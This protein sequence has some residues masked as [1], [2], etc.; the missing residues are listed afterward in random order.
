MF[1]NWLPRT[2]TRTIPPLR[3]GRRGASPRPSSRLRLEALEDR[4]APATHIWVGPTVGGLWSAAANWNGGAPT[5][6]EAGGTIV[7]FNG[8][9][10][11]IDDIAGLVVNQIHFT[12]D[13]NT[14]RGITPLGIDGTTV[15][16]NLLNDAGS[17][18]LDATLPLVLSGG[19]FVALLSAG[20]VTI[21]GSVSGNEGLNLATGSAGTLVLGG[22]AANTYTGTTTIQDG[23]LLLSKP[24]G[25]NAVGGNVSVG[26]GNGVLLS[27]VL[28]LAAG[29]QI[30]DAATVTVHADGLFDLFDNSDT[31]TALNI[32]G[33][34]VDSGGGTLTLSGNVTA[35]SDAA[36]DAAS[37]LG[38]LALGAGS[39]TVSD[40]PVAATNDLVVAATITGGTGLTLT[41]AS[42]GQMVVS[43]P[44]NAY[45]GGTIVLGGTLILGT[46]NA[47]P[48]P[49]QVAAD[50]PL[51][52]TAPGTLDLNGFDQEVASINGTG[53]I[54]DSGV[55]ATLTANNAAA[56]TFAGLLSGSLD[57][58]KNNI[59]TLTLTASNT[60]SGPT[61]INA[62]TLA[63]GIVDALPAGTSVIVAAAGT[64]D[65]AGFNQTVASITGAGTITD[66]SAT[67]ATLTVNN[68]SDEAFDG[69]LSGKLALTKAGNGALTLQGTAANTYTGTTTITDGTLVLN[70]PAGVNA[71]GGNVTVGDGI[72]VL[73]SD[74]LQLA[75]SN[76][77]PDSATVTV[78]SDGLF[79]LF[80]NSET[81]AALNI[82]GG[83]VDSGGGTLTLLGNVTATSDAAGD[84]ASILGNLALGAGAGSFVVT[85]GP[86]AA[87]NDLVVAA[88]LTG[89]TGLTLT[90][91]STGQMVLSAPD[92]AYTGG[93]MI[94]GGTLLLGAS[95]ALPVPPQ[96]A[97]DQPL[98]VT[99][100][101]TLDLNGFDQEVASISGTGTITDSGVQATLT[102]NNTAADTFAGL[103]S[104]SLALT[105]IG[106]GTLTLT[107][108][109]T[110]TGPTTINAGTLLVNGTQ[111]NSS[112]SVF[113]P[114]TLGGVGTTGPVNAGI[115]TPATAGGTVAPGNPIGTL[116]TGSIV[117][118]QGANFNVDINGTTPGT[119]FDVLNVT[120][121]VT[122]TNANLRIS[123]NISIPPGT[124][125][126]IL[127]NDGADPISGT[128]SGLPEGARFLVNGQRFSISYVGGDGNDIVLTRVNLSDLAIAKTGPAGPVAEGT[129]ITYMITV[130]NSGPDD[131][132]N[133]VVTDAVPAGA[134]LN[135]LNFPQGARGAGNTFNLG[136]VTNGATVTG[137]AVITATEEGALNDVA[138]VSSTSTDPNSANNTSTATT[139]VTE[140]AISLIGAAINGFEFM[141]P[142][143]PV[144]VATLIHANGVEPATDFTASINWGDGTSS[145]GQVTL[146]GLTYSIKGGHV[147]NDEGTFHVTV[148]V[149]E[150]NGSNSTTTTATILEELLP[151][152]TR[153]TAN[154]RFLSEV[155]RNMLARKI[156]SA[157][158]TTWNAEL[159]AGATRSQVVHDIQDSPS[160]EFRNDEVQALY[161]QFLHRAADPTG[162]NNAVAFLRSG[163]TVEQLA[164][165]LV[166]SAEYNQRTNGSN[167]GW[168]DTIY[169]DALHRAV[170]A[171]GRVGWDA[172]FAAG[173]SR[174][175]V[176]SAIFA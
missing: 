174:A 19:N 51:T 64:Y 116:N 72:G 135:S 11:S 41:A 96:V 157:G 162:L 45:T 73:L 26:D 170:D 54:T 169:Q 10:D 6:G 104:G 49:P 172:A 47:L 90:A 16:N 63:N 65:L 146:T 27:D 87:T 124:T 13:A 70:K 82:T 22:I 9:I 25:V 66:S 38:N 58:T 35:T 92:N 18:T 29:N 106:A 165:V 164:V 93:T 5:S 74:V 42:T 119:Q 30:P 46:S 142:V 114:G 129:P 94:L 37:I 61:T 163:G 173:A 44:D 43:A 140:A 48:V 126:L 57:L 113:A 85:D 31:I 28:Q 145:A 7:Q 115:D 134:I 152:G 103:L 40:G 15:A 53:T 67:A 95:N 139:T 78:Q 171:M 14:I 176:A 88:T 125:L 166:A 100:P 108:N 159:S 112:V 155:Y 33:G 127:S 105:K 34:R 136:T 24:D 91:A 156:D 21:A 59:G 39:F 128:F 20:Q 84:A 12:A 80:D 55:E 153:G 102:V 110:Y 23:T 17:S 143:D 60:Y 32:D 117:F 77:I 69:V 138:S 89:A 36:G 99:A 118:T 56:D 160:N 2:L 50:Q 101:G 86:V 75:A 83:R 130:T 141:A 62:G 68:A 121:T 109:N 71:V 123:P 175:Q 97:A 137:T 52:V 151:D 8:G 79:D 107:G 131:A 161:R 81:I 76:Q 3:Q 111:P 122:I 168:L 133:V 98:T 1:R 144:T 149:S 148:T 132:Q 120:G 158:L 154:Q 167:D 150:D 4:L 147:Y